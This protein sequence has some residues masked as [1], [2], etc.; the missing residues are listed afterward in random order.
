MLI[1]GGF[2]LTGC[3]SGQEKKIPLAIEPL[4]QASMAEQK[5]RINAFKKA[6]AFLPIRGVI[7]NLAQYDNKI[8]NKK[9]ITLLANL[10]I[11]KV[12]IQISSLEELNNRLTLFLAQAKEKNI[13]PEIYISLHKFLLPTYRTTF[14]KLFTEEPVNFPG[15]VKA[16]D[17]YISLL[18][19]DC[20]NVNLT[21]Q[22][23]P[24]NFTSSFIANKRASLYM[25]SEENY[26]INKDNDQLFNAS[27]QAIENLKLSNNLKVTVAL[28]DFY[29]KLALENK[30]SKSKITDILALRKNS[31]DAMV[32]STGNQPS[33][34]IKQAISNL[35]SVKKGNVLIT[36]VLA[37]HSGITKGAFRHRDWNDLVRSFTFF[38]RYLRRY[39]AL[40]G[41]VIDS[42]PIMEHLL[43]E[44]K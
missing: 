18:P 21:I 14:D 32:I 2:I 6:T 8:E 16:I 23:S 3:A 11:N 20:K 13:S 36:L 4:R 9:L 38:N 44:S 40:K 37:S 39:P 41:F 17:N 27:T 12:Y 35:T 7:L 26:G 33:Q 30:L 19:N 5:S 24:H 34:V 1:L 28:K 15:L 31:V 42:L 43:L 29:H 10:G 25:W 22:L